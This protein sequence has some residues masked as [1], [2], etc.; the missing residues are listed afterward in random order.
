MLDNTSPSFLT[1]AY[2]RRQ[3]T[4]RQIAH[5][6][7]TPQVRAKLALDIIEGRVEVTRF[8]VRQAAHLCRVS[9]PVVNAARK[10]PAD[11]LVAAWN[12]ATNAER[13][14]FAQR[15]GVGVVFDTAIAPA[16]ND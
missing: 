11:R 8:T 16:L 3:I 5:R 13:V 2:P 15:I 14:Q 4:G 7:L 12:G 9:V 10:S 6:R 1:T